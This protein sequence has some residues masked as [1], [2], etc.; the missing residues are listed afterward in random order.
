M[1]FHY[2]R[3]FFEKSGLYGFLSALED[4]GAEQENVHC[5]KE[6]HQNYEG[7]H[8]FLGSQRCQKHHGKAK[9]N[10]GE[11]LVDQ[12]VSCRCFE[13][14]V[15]LTQQDNAGAGSTREH[16]EHRQELLL[17]VIGE[18]LAADGVLIFP[19]ESGLGFAGRRPF[20]VPGTGGFY[21]ALLKGKGQN[22][23][24]EMDRQL[25]KLL[26]SLCPTNLEST[27]SVAIRG[28]G[29]PNLESFVVPLNENVPRILIS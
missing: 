27:S 23:L 16:T 29:L 18:Q 26:K 28:V 17:H 11:V 21:I 8:G 25:Q 13:V 9:N 2:H 3:R 5:N 19:G 10:G 22:T 4:F 24:S 1:I 15:N 6:K 12:V 14:A 20:P 7:Q